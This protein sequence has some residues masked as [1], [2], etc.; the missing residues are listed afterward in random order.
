ME[1]QMKAFVQRMI[2]NAMAAPASNKS[3]AAE[4]RPIP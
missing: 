2:Q 1:N 4:P 3:I